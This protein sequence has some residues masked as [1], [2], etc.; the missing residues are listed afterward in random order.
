MSNRQT[1]IF[2]TKGHW[3]ALT[4]KDINKAQSNSLS[5]PQ[6]D[7]HFPEKHSEINYKDTGPLVSRCMYHDGN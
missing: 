7:I 2:F 3:K 6:K 1:T 5:Y 4:S